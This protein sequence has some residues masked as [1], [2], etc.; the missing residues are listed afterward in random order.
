MIR[1]VKH[2]TKFTIT[3]TDG[4][5]GSVVDFYFDDE[6]WAIRYLVVDTGKWWPG[7]KV[8]IS[9]ISVM[10]AE[11]GNQR[12]LLSLPRDRVRNAPDIDTHKPVSRQHESA[13]FDYYGYPYYWGAPGL[14]G[15]YPTPMLPTAGEI[16]QAGRQVAAEGQRAAERGDAHLRSASEVTGYTI[17]ATDGDLGHVED[18]MF[19]DVSWAVRY[20]VI[21][22]SNWWFGKHVLIAPDW[23]SNIN[24]S[25]R[26]VT[27]NVSR[28]VLKNAPAYDRAAHLDR[29]W[30]AAYY[31][32][33]QQP[34]YWLDAGDA[35]AAKTAQEY[36]RES[37]ESPEDPLERR[38]LPR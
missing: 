28:Q 27:V 11:W 17:H 20:L 9:P 36:L 19:D 38:A 5:V 12:L 3:A 29:Q 1:S 33:L 26:T 21:D 6:R 34:G 37:A 35:R 2:L 8:L 14:W 24:W 16:A 10:R 18:L 22:T 32:H 15:A 23:I 4:D 25:N 7:R 30:E 31:Q 13:Y